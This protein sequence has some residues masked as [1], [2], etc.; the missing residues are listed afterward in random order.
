M[1]VP[2]GSAIWKSD[3]E[4][5]YGSAIFAD[6]WYWNMCSLDELDVGIHFLAVALYERFIYFHCFQGQQGHFS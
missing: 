6:V 2:Y 3:M 1:E 4:V 5:P